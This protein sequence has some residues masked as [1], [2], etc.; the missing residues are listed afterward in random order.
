MDGKSMKDSFI[1]S[2]KNKKL[3]ICF[4]VYSPKALMR[5]SLKT[6]ATRSGSTKERNYEITVSIR[7]RPLQNPSS[8]GQ[9]AVEVD[10]STG[11]L[12]VNDKL[13]K[14]ADHIICGSDQTICYET[15]SAPLIS[16][17]QKGISCCL[18]AYGQTGSGKTHTIFGPPGNVYHPILWFLSYVLTI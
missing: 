2:D 4:E 6:R 18:L 11:A 9:R 17:L 13:Y 5:D 1:P 8:I 15:T 10:P 12:N 14:F 7:V 16:K 3:N